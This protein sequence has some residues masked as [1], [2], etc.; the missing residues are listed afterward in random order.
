MLGQGHAPKGDLPMLMLH[1]ESRTQGGALEWLA[2][3]RACSIQRH[4]VAT[5]S[6]QSH[7]YRKSIGLGVG[8]GLGLGSGSGLG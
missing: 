3:P 8:L 6:I 4:A 5:R 7:G 2:R 1:S